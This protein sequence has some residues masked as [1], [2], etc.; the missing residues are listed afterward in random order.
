MKASELLTMPKMNMVTV[1][2]SCSVVQNQLTKYLAQ[3][4]KLTWVLQIINNVLYIVK[5]LYNSQHF[6]GKKKK[7]TYLIR[8]F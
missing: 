8:T 7:S 5:I 1:I 6:Q 3:L 4:I 2:I